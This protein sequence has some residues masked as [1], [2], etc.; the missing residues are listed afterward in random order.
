MVQRLVQSRHPFVFLRGNTY[1]FRY[2]LPL[3]LRKLYPSLLA[4]VKSSLNAD[5]YSEA[6]NMVA[7]KIP[8]I[9]LLRRCTNVSA[10][11]ALFDFS[12][13]VKAW[14]DER[15]ERLSGTVRDVEKV[16]A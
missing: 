10:V 5:S 9:K 4:E 8:I 1:Y 13:Q 2:A 11:E 3:H 7:Q 6:V 14:V 16:M 12:E 15:L